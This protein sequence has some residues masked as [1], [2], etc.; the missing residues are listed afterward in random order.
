M[1]DILRAEHDAGENMKLC[2]LLAHK[3]EVKLDKE[4]RND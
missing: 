4:V 2:V 3:I 1:Q